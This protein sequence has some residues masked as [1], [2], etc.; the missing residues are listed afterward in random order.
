MP[1]RGRAVRSD[2]GWRALDLDEK[3]LPDRWIPSNAFAL[4]EPLKALMTHFLQL[5]LCLQRTL[6]KSA[7]YSVTSASHAVLKQKKARLYTFSLAPHLPINCPIPDP[8]RL[9]RS[10]LLYPAPLPHLLPSPP[11]PS[12]ARAPTP[13]VPT[14]PQAPPARHPC[15]R[16]A[17]T[18]PHAT[19]W[20][21]LSPRVEWYIR[22]FS[23]CTPSLASESF[24][25]AQTLPRWS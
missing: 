12:R 2:L 7:L 17:V 6:A 25:R 5:A 24:S 3:G 13:P 9:P 1:G 8:P 18:L 14:Q 20:E 23:V 16:S 10:P 19:E 15:T 21:L 11:P 4:G 22:V